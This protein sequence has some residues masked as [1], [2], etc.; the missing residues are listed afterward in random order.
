MINLPPQ[1]YKVSCL[2][3]EGCSNKQMAYGLH[4]S[5]STIKH[6][7]QLIMR[8]TNTKNRTHAA[9]VLERQSHDEAS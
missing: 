2:L 9:L 5:E 1:T 7:I 6:H 4:L 8:A 3:L